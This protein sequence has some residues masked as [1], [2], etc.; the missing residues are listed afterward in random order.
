MKIAC[1]GWGSLIWDPKKLNIATQWFEDGPLLPIELTR[2]SKDKRVTFIIDESAM[3][4]PTLWALMATDSLENAKESLKDREDTSIK[5]IHCI[6]KFDV[7]KGNVDLII[8][9]WLFIKGLDY[10]IWTGLSFSKKTQ[11]D[12]PGIDLIINH[13]KD[14]TVD[15]KRKAEE[16]I[17]RAPAQ[18]NTEYRKLI[19]TEF[20]W[21]S[22][23]SR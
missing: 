6:G 16:Y 14:L 4:V 22:I 23:N 11:S 12:R 17:R 18:V 8:R 21:Y 5:N 13:L 15:E 19:E 1:I 20:G 9:D 7:P 10:A 3:N 2:I